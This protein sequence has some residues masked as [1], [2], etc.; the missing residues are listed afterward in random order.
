MARAAGDLAAARAAYQASPDIA[1]GLA[2]A[3]PASTEWQREREA[4]RQ[5]IG[6]LDG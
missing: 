1:E 4:M 2:V 5:K 3:D 6:S